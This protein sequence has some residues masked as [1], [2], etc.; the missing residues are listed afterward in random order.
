[1]TKILKPIQ[2]PRVASEGAHAWFPRPRTAAPLARIR[3][4]P[5][6]STVAGRRAGGGSGP[7]EAGAGTAS[8]ASGDCESL[9]P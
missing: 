9:K 7:P 2:N 4:G 1:M 8:A 5:G 6:R 3:A